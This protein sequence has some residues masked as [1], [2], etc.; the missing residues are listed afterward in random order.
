MIAE[1]AAR[2]VLDFPREV[3]CPC[4][5]RFQDDV[6]FDDMPFYRVRLAYDACFGDGRMVEYRAFHLERADA[7]A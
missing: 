2:R 5:P 6:G 4:F 7:I 3:R 1:G